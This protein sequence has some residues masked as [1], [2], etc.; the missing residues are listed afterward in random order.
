MAQVVYT[1]KKGDTLTPIAK[2][3]GVTVEQI[4]KLNKLKKNSRGNY[5]IYVGQQLIIDRY[6]Q[7]GNGLKIIPITTKLNGITTVVIMF[8]LKVVS[9]PKQCNNLYIVHHRM[10]NE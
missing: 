6:L 4:V 9:V 10:L 7:L 1:V 2:K 8:G 3:Y 5:L